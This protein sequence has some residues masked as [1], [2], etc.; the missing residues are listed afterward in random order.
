[1]PVSAQLGRQAHDLP[2]DQDKCFRGVVDGPELHQI[3][4]DWEPLLQQRQV[5]GARQGYDRPS[6]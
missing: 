5:F 1:M 4:P 2:L 3:G 6:G